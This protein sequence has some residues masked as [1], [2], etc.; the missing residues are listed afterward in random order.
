MIR[1]MPALADDK[2]LVTF[3]LP[4]SIWAADVHLVGDFNEWNPTAHPLRQDRGGDWMITLELEANQRYEFR[5][6]RV[7]S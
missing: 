1:K 5:Y 6:L 3:E 7:T 2:I 4:G